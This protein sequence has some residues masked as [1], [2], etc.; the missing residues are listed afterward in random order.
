MK[1]LVQNYTFTPGIANAGTVV[2][3][4]LILTLEQVLLITNV[5]TG[6]IIYDFS[7]PTQGAVLTTGGGNTTLTLEVDTSAMLASHRLQIFYELRQ[8]G[9]TSETQSLSVVPA[10]TIEVIGPAAQSALN[11]N[12]LTGNTSWYNCAGYRGASFLIVASPGITAGQI[13]FEQTVAGNNPVT[14]VVEEQNTTTPTSH[15]TNISIIANTTRLFSC[16]LTGS[17]VRIR[18]I[19]GFTGGT[20]QCFALFNQQPYQRVVTGSLLTGGNNIG[21]VS[22]ATNSQIINREVLPTTTTDIASAAITA[23]GTTATFTVSQGNA[24][25]LYVDITAI[26]GTVNNYTIAI[27]ESHNSGITWRITHVLPV[28]VAIG[29]YV[30]GPFPTKGDRIRYAQTISGTTPSITR[31]ILRQQ[32]NSQTHTGAIPVHGNGAI[33]TGGTAQTVNLTLVRRGLFS[34]QNHSAQD[35]WLRFTPGSAIANQH[36]KVAPGSTLTFDK[37]VIPTMMDFSVLGSTTG[38][39]FSW[40]EA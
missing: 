30:F 8:L 6:Q 19:A 32:L 27:E 14:L 3:T 36:F 13:I 22:L 10:Q 39:L 33:T 35:L 1:Q 31:S 26:S 21:I 24:Y 25:C 18:I 2:L 40:I 9:L 16:P 5:T 12:L 7:E 15:Q 28:P 17:N 11:N 29:V 4:G 20:I 38:Q 34:F 23:N 37:N